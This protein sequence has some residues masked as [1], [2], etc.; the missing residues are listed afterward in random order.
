VQRKF[1]YRV[2]DV[3]LPALFE[4]MRLS[5]QQVAGLEVYAVK[6]TPRPNDWELS[7]TFSRWER[8][9]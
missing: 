4:W 8:K 3:N 1:R 7:V 5:T 2:Q 9:K 6:L